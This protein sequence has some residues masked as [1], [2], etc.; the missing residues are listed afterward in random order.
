MIPKLVSMKRKPVEKEDDD[1]KGG[2]CCPSTDYER[3]DYPWGTRLNLETEQL[4]ALGLT[5]GN[6]PAVGTTM[7]MVG[8]VV[9]VSSGSESVDGGK[10]N[11]RLELQV[12]DMALDVPG[13]SLAERMYGGAKPAAK[14]TTT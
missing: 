4:Q 2:E 11:L 3:P 5:P 1:E 9:V 7:D 12:T 14:T 13:P 8:K 6:M 10:T